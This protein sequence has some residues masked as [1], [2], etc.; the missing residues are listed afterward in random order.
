MYT[1]KQVETGDQLLPCELSSAHKRQHFTDTH[2]YS[3]SRPAL[4]MMS[5]HYRVLPRYELT[6]GFPNKV[7]AASFFSSSQ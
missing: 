4:I 1:N 5:P 2:F 6:L 7:L 3:F